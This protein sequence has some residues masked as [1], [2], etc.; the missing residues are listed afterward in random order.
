MPVSLLQIWKNSMLEE[1]RQLLPLVERNYND[2]TMQ[3]S[4]EFKENLKIV[5]I[6]NKFAPQLLITCSDHPEHEKHK[7]KVG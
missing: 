2:K 6:A 7:P 4:I 5:F 3:S 1:Q